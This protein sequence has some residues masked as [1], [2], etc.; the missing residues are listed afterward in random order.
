M[1]NE[2]T[3]RSH[4]SRQGD[5]GLSLFERPGEVDLESRHRDALRCGASSNHKQSQPRGARPF[6]HIK[7]LPHPCVSTTPRP[8]SEGLVS[9]WL[10]GHLFDC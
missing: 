1:R 10:R 3:G 5:I 4:H 9:A 8:R 2:I 7:V 6:I